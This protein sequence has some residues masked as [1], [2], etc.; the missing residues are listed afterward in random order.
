[1]SVKILDFAT[2]QQAW[3]GINEYLFTE[4]D[5]VTKRGGSFHGTQVL[6]Y[7]I[8]I[9][10]RR[11]RVD[12]D[13]DFAHVLGYSIQKWS[14]LVNNYVNFEYLDILK[15]QILT[16]ERKGNSNYNESM[17]FD[18][19][20]NSGKGCL[21]SLTFSRRI[22]ELNPTLI[23]CLRSSEVT[24]RLLFDFLLIQRIGEYVYGS[25]QEFGIQLYCPNV[26]LDV[27]AFC[28]Y[29]NHRKLK[30][31]KSDREPCKVQIKV[32]KLFQ[33]FLDTDPDKIT[34]RSHLRVVNQIQR[35]VNGNPKDS[36]G[37]NLFAKNLIFHFVESDLPDDI[38]TPKE[39]RA[40]KR[41]KKKN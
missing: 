13:F 21:L 39:I 19:S 20:H 37:R 9:R 27:A 12:P 31:I 23:F 40:Y 2:T 24:K 25:K 30:S 18:N 35:D 28:M 1:M 8:M 4:V 26:Y 33:K 38:N 22:N 5:E 3:E 17:L 34:Y 10:A 6:S 41:N 7:D 16:R 32:F 36:K 29:D 14:S 15:G 11:A